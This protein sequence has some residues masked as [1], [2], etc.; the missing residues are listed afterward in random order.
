MRQVTAAAVQ[1][2][3]ALELDYWRLNLAGRKPA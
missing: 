2:N 3:P 1:D